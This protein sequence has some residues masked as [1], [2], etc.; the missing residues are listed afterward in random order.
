[1][2]YYV[3]LLQSWFAKVEELESDVQKTISNF[4]K[5]APER[6]EMIQH[7]ESV[8]KRFPLAS[9][10]SILIILT[11]LTGISAAL[12]YQSDI[13]LTFLLPP[14]VL[15]ELVSLFLFGYVLVRQTQQLASWTMKLRS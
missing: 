9:S 6:L 13:P 5:G 7:C 3:F 2:V 11:V 1:V 4:V 15:Y 10:L 14:I 8:K 12:S